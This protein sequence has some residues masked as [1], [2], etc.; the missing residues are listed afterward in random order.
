MGAPWRSPVSSDKTGPDPNTDVRGAP[1]GGRVYDPDL[2]PAKPKVDLADRPQL[3]QLLA[4]IQAEEPLSEAPPAEPLVPL[5][6]GVLA[7]GGDEAASGYVPPAPLPTLREHKTMDRER[8]RIGPKAA[9]RSVATSRIQREGAME[10]AGAGS[11]LRQADGEAGIDPRL[12]PSAPRLRAPKMP[13]PALQGA[14]RARAAPGGLRRRRLGLGLLG[15][16]LG[17]LMGA[18]LWAFWPEGGPAQK[19]EALERQA[20]EEG[21]RTGEPARGAAPSAL[22]TAPSS[23]MAP[24]APATVASSAS[25]TGLSTAP[26]APP[27]GSE[28]PNASGVGSV[29]PA[30]R[31]IPPGRPTG[32]PAPRPT[33]EPTV[34]PSAAPPMPEVAAPPSV[35][36]PVPMFKREK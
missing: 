18:V 36:P 11:R 17:M 14:R 15:G 20:R 21:V 10:G 2:A 5:E 12:L 4:E 7:T 9:S 16:L 3:Q 32:E 8:V 24:V 33:P 29:G 26:A 34:A 28:R 25:P 27:P 23:A 19:G 35:S 13:A 30:P 22:P 31:S 1:F 6:H